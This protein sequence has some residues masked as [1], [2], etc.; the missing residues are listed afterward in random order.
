M[1]ALF[2]PT[3]ITDMETA[4]AAVRTQCHAWRDILNTITTAADQGHNAFRKGVKA[5]SQLKEALETL[6]GVKLANNDDYSVVT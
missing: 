2:T 5:H 6:R 3:Q 4:L 1:A